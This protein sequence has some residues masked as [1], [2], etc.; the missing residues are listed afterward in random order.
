SLDEFALRKLQSLERRHLRRA[1][2]VTEPR[3]P[4][5]VHRDGR[6]LISF[7]SN[8]YLGLSRHPEVVAA[9]IEATRRYG[10]GAGASRLVTGNH[11]PYEELEQRL[12]E[13]KG[14]EQAVVF[15][16]GYLTNIGTL[17]VL[18]GARDLI[19]IDELCH[20]CLGTGAQLSGAR[21]LQFPHNDSEGAAT[22]LA[23]H[24]QA[25]RHC[26]IVTDGVFSM[27]GDLAPLPQLAELAER[28]DC[29]L[30]TDD[31]HA[32]GVVGGG[33]GSSFAFGG[34]IQVPLQMG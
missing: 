18:A 25:Y 15:G 22:L 5:R 2:V 30:M 13:L 9:S 17:P 26:L 10:A 12:A 6:E 34:A 16:S 14:S 4:S 19:L 23:T 8:D 32:L 7:S 11:P 1:L 20:S 29:W 27:E 3:S 33:R 24:R 21:V 31:A 28:Y